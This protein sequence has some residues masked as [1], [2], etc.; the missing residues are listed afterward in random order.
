MARKAWPSKVQETFFGEGTNGR[1]KRFA[2]AVQ[3]FLSEPFSVRAPGNRIVYVVVDAIQPLETDD[4][5]QLLLQFRLSDHPPPADHETLIGDNEAPQA[6]ARDYTDEGEDE[7]EPVYWYPFTSMH[8]LSWNKENL[9]SFVLANQEAADDGE[10]RIAGD[11]TD[12]E[13]RLIDG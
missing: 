6:F 9:R 5:Y 10:I 4:D 11:L 7:D 2:P 3:E 8:S 12:R 13:D 1:R